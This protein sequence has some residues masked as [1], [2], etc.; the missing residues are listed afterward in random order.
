M[1]RTTHV[2]SVAGR[3]AS[4]GGGGPGPV[5]RRALAL[6]LGAGLLVPWWPAIPADAQSDLGFSAGLAQSDHRELSSPSALGVSLE[7]GLPGIP[8]LKLRADYR[9][10]RDRSSWT[11]CFGGGPLPPGVPPCEPVPHEGDFRAHSGDAGLLLRIPLGGRMDLAGIVAGTVWRVSGA[12]EEANGEGRFRAARGLTGLGWSQ[13]VEL[14]WRPIP[15]MVLR[16]AVRH[17]RPRFDNC[18]TDAY[19]A[20]CRTHSFRGI[21]MGL[22]WL[23]GG[24]S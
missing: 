16:G 6:I 19:F 3:A 1:A 18:G 4:G 8:F 14:R 13:A 17:E 2:S 21:E 7:R 20:F 12:W 10:R 9:Y 22:T 11:T 24:T 23:R 15:W 5:G